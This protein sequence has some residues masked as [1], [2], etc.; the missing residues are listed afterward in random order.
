MSTGT[1]WLR[2]RDSPRHP[3]PGATEAAPGLQSLGCGSREPLG[4]GGAGRSHRNLGTAAGKT[5]PSNLSP[6]PDT[7]ADSPLKPLCRDLTR[8]LG[9]EGPVVVF[10]FA[11]GEPQGMCPA[12]SCKTNTAEAARTSRRAARCSSGVAQGAVPLGLA[13]ARGRGPPCGFQPGWGW[14]RSAAPPALCLPSCSSPWCSGS[15]QQPRTQTRRRAGSRPCSAHLQLPGPPGPGDTRCMPP[16]PA[17]PSQS[18]RVWHRLRGQRAELWG[19]R[20]AHPRHGRGHQGSDSDLG[21]QQGGQGWG[22][23]GTRGVSPSP[24]WHG[25]ECHCLRDG[26]GQHD[27]MAWPR[28]PPCAQP[29]SQAAGSGGSSFSRG[30]QSP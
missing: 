17:P 3:Q 7:R 23:H 6:R 11:M 25:A 27:P 5:P 22:L 2:H 16:P 12:P 4:A 14:G 21:W 20:S 8:S 30:Q 26:T 24:G 10:F 9:L 13:A 1:A 15:Q 28:T 29:H 19:L 18:L